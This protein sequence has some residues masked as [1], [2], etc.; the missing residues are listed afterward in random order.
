[1]ARI[2]TP[3]EFGKWYSEQS[4][5]T[6]KQVRMLL[7]FLTGDIL[8]TPVGAACSFIMAQAEAPSSE[9]DEVLDNELIAL[10]FIGENLPR[11]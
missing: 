8:K 6:R 7:S 1:M 9:A 2:V 3:S 10:R 11:N 4:D 5:A